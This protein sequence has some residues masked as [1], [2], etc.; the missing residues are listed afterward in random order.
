MAGASRQSVD[1][2]VIVNHVWGMI[3]G[4]GLVRTPDDFGT[5]GRRPTH[6]QLLDHLAARFSENW[7]IKQLIRLMVTSHT[8]RQSSDVSADL[9][10]R[11]PE[12]LHLARASRHRLPSW[13]IRDAQLQASGL[14]ND[15]L[16]GPPV[17]PYQPAGV[18]ADITMG[19]FRY[20]PS[21]GPAGYRRTLYTFWRRSSAPAFLFDASPRRVCSVSDS[22]TNT[23]LHAL[24]LMNDRTGLEA[25]A[26]LADQV[27]HQ[28]RELRKQI[29]MLS[30][31]VLLRDPDAAEL[32]QLKTLHAQALSHFQAHPSDASDLLPQKDDGNIE[33]AAMTV[34]ASVLLN[35][36]EAIT[37]E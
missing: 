24:T 15:R 2:R 8:Y 23:P 6:P 30:Q 13:M 17:R 18:W 25:A 19:R 33:K 34:V 20:E 22:R 12:N 31:H 35:L 7:D 29:V 27:I 36:D 4:A 37:R 21:V 16:G 10:E 32:K 14:L 26:H 3:F 5:Q 28:K 1:G 11:D 9:L